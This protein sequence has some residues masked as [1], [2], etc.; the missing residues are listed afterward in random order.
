[1]RYITIGRHP[2]TPRQKELLAKAGLKEEV[3]R[4]VQVNDVNEVIVKA[5]EVNAKAIVV[6]ALPMHL[7][8]QLLQATNRAGIPVL[9]FEMETIASVK[10]EEKCPEG[11]EVE[12]PAEGGF[13][14]CIRTK[15]LVRVKRIVVETEPIAE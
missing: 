15:R 2:F 14:R 10:A 9:Q 5:K 1:M 7:L 12:R 8:A 11:T 4:V 13:K 3:A 6:Q